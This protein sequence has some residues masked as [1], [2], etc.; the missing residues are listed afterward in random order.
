MRLWAVVSVGCAALL[1]A[2]AVLVWS[3]WGAETCDEE[4]QFDWWT[5]ERRAAGCVMYD[6]LSDSD[7]LLSRLVEDDAIPHL[8]LL[9][10]ELSQNATQ[11]PY[12]PT[13]L[14]PWTSLSLQSIPYARFV[15][16]PLSQGVLV[17]LT[18]DGVYP[19]FGLRVHLV[20]FT[21][22]S[23]LVEQGG[24]VMVTAPVI[25][26]HDPLFNL[27]VASSATPAYNSSTLQAILTDF[28]APM[29]YVLLIAYEASAFHFMAVRHIMRCIVCVRENPISVTWIVVLGVL[30]AAATISSVTGYCIR[31][32]NRGLEEEVV[33]LTAH[34]QQQPDI[35]GQSN[36]AADYPAVVD[37]QEEAG[38]LEQR[39]LG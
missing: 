34:H 19:D 27:T 23:P 13:E 18:V 37:V 6:E 9:S 35:A 7:Q 22:D 21:K 10:A 39:L 16:H 36:A 5:E 15:F 38:G 20:G 2:L 31:R 11:T 28:Y 14:I 30:Q 3:N 17:D 33:A 24:I 29:S 26:R 1:C 25:D 4:V 12:Q 32:C 8:S